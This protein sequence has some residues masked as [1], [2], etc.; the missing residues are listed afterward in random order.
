MSEKEIISFFQI[1]KRV[2]ERVDS[3]GRFTAAL[4]VPSDIE[5]L[6]AVLKAYKNKLI[7]PILIGDEKLIKNKADENLMSLDGIEILDLNQPDMAIKTAT[8]MAIANE[9][10]FIVKGKGDFNDFV[11]LLLDE[12]S[13]FV[14]SR[15]TVSHI[16]VFKA[17]LY[18]KLLILTDSF[19][20]IAQDIKQ[21]VA[22]INNAVKLARQLN[23]D[24]PKV[25][26]L[27]AVE[28]IYPQ[29]PVTVDAAAIAKMS[30]RKQ[31]PNAIVDGPLSFD[32]AVDPVA[33]E[34]KGITNSKVA[35]DA[36][37]IIPSTIE[38]ANGVYKSMSLF[39][40][41]EIGGIIYG[42]KVPVAINPSIDSFENRYNSILL[43]CLMCSR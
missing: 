28:V 21:K 43:A 16:A 4:P 34:A 9:I 30:D 29:M 40:K 42:G 35:G 22:I 8:K 5:S 15:K 17:E 33:A 18:K 39:A 20:N 38:T 37:I 26:I 2:K 3:N 32:I 12:K 10:D 7:E 11:D 14:S 6:K 31:I 13:D 19:V 23:I 24:C 27:A 41:A 1:E 25:A 36:D